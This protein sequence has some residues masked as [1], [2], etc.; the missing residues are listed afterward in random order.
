MA[1]FNTN[2]ARHFYVAKT[3]AVI[4]GVVTPAIIEGMSVGDL[5]VVKDLEG[6]LAFLYKNAD[7]IITRSDTIEA[8]KIQY[9]TRKTAAELALPLMAHTITLDTNNYAIADLAGKTVVATITVREILSYD[10]ADS[11]S[12]AAVVKVTNGMTAAQFY[13]ALKT[14]I[15][16]AMP[17]R[18]YPYFT[19]T[20]GSSNV[21]LTMAPQKYRR[22]LMSN[23]SVDLVVSFNIRGTDDNVESWGKDDVAKSASAT[24]PAVYALADLEY[25]SLGE[26]GDIYRGSTWP[27]NYEP[28]YMINPADNTFANYG[29]L[30]IQYFWQGN[31]EN[32]QKSPRT[33]QVAG[34]AAALTTLEGA[35]KE[36]MGESE[37][38]APTS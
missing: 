29:V 16:K 1:N 21:V 4:D 19:V 28:T 26:R 14:A 18:E 30:S 6:N 27:N 35:V 33:I 2:Q 22:G 37:Q 24:I 34:P 8:G 31:A 17:K 12:Y 20:G 13:A 10:A 5:K 3:A 23:E 38:T 11:I 7:G 9:Y 36:A 32:I 25:F 15:E